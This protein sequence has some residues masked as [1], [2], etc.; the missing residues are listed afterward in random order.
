MKTTEET[1]NQVIVTMKLSSKDKNKFPLSKLRP[2]PKSSCR[3]NYCFCV[4][5]LDTSS[6]SSL[7]KS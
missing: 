5:F 7:N 3:E 2:R 1:E 4:V 6:F